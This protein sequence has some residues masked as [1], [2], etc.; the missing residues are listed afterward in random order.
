MIAVE[1]GGFHGSGGRS[2]LNVR[3]PSIRADEVLILVAY[4]GICSSDISAYKTGNYVIGFTIR[5]EFSGEYTK[6]NIKE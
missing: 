5:H 6:Y 2:V 3:K 1:G 4:F